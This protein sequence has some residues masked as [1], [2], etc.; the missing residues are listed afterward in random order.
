VD[1]LH[2]II[3]RCLQLGEHLDRDFEGGWAIGD[4]EGEWWAI[5]DGR[6]EVVGRIH[7]GWAQKMNGRRGD[8]GPGGEESGC[9]RRGFLGRL[10]VLKDVLGGRRMVMFSASDA[11][12]GGMWLRYVRML[13]SA[14][15]AEAKDTKAICALGGSLCDNGG[16][17]HV[18]FG[19]SKMNLGRYH[20][21]FWA[22]I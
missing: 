3:L 14:W 7:P 11:D 5:G 22:G 17:S 2:F 16:Q 10:T 8:Q 1:L 9:G 20:H 15:S 6:S 13:R 4:G 12:K 18:L 21:R 19:G